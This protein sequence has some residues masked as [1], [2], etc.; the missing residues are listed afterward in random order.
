M[1]TPTINNSFTHYA[2]YT[3]MVT[4]PSHKITDH[5]NKEK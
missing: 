3:H 4:S 2:Q 5:D 1:L